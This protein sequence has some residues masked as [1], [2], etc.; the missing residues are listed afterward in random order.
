MEWHYTVSFS[1]VVCILFYYIFSHGE[2]HLTLN[3]IYLKRKKKKKNSC[4][5][6]DENADNAIH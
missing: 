3:A 1:L 2:N 6:R 5:A 4:K